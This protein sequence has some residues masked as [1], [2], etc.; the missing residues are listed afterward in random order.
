MQ[1]HVSYCYISRA[2]WK[3]FLPEHFFGLNEISIFIN[4]AFNHQVAV[5]VVGRQ[6]V[7]DDSTG[8]AESSGN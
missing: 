1:H 8:D 5:A 3:V 6:V 7:G 2:T 4:D